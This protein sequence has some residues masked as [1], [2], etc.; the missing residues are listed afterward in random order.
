[1]GFDAP[2]GVS[3]IT[4]GQDRVAA[5]DRIARLPA[6][7]QEAARRAAAAAQPERMKF[8]GSTT[9]FCRPVASS[10]WSGVEKYREEI[11]TL[12]KAN[13][14]LNRRYMALH[15]L[16]GYFDTAVPSMDEPRAGALPDVRNLFVANT[17]LRLKD[18]AAPR[19]RSAVLADLGRD[20]AM[21][22]AVVKGEGSVVSKMVAINNLHGD[23]ALLGDIIGDWTISWSAHASEVAAMLDHLAPADWKIGGA[24]PM[25]S[26]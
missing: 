11:R 2:P 1:M 5:A 18:A 4:V 14:E 8:S 17:A 25:N 23:L 10:C 12:L 19:E 22:R 16:P 21:W 26:G 13:G 7:D 15:A 3:T 24:P 6:K 9:G 20:I